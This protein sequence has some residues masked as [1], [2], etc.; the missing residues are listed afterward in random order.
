[1]WLSSDEELFRFC[2][3][4]P[5]LGSDHQY[6]QAAYLKMAFGTFCILTVRKL[7]RGQPSTTFSC[8]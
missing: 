4:C 7:K 2:L 5:P 1:M 6:K 3:V 8:D